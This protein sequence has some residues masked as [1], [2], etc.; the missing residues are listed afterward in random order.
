VAAVAEGELL[1]RLR[2]RDDWRLTAQRRVIAEALA[3]DHVHMTA[4]EVLVAA[5]DRLPE[6]SVATVY[7]TLNE[8][9]E[10]GELL[11]FRSGDGPK[12]YDPNTSR[13]HQHLVCVE[14]GEVLDVD[15]DRLPTL[16]VPDRHGFEVLAVDVTVRGRCPDCSEG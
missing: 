8:L 9:V 1:E 10:L 15:V 6:V 11:E 7:N 14:C 12:R 2:A 3:G 5:R 13:P 4:E 16:S